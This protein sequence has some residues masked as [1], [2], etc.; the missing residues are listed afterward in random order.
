MSKAMTDDELQEQVE[1]LY[2]TWFFNY[3]QAEPD[4][5]HTLVLHE[6]HDDG[7]GD[8][9]KEQLMQLIQVRDEQREIDFRIAE[10]EH[11]I[12]EYEN[13]LVKHDA[14]AKELRVYAATKLTIDAHRDRIANL[15]ALKNKGKTE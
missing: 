8:D 1:R 7:A 13:A 15:Q 10:N 9:L 6:V 4:E 11:I 14:F 5:T 2:D 12:Q 3:A